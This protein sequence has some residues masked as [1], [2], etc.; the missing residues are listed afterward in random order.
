MA[1][2][3]VNPKPFLNDLTGKL[4]LVKLK[5]GMEYKGTLKSID[6]YMNLQVLNTEEWVEAA[7]GAILARS[8][9]VATMCSI[10]EECRRRSLTWTEFLVEVE[11]RCTL[12]QVKQ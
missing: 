3:P 4:I 2:V 12:R 6:P 10:S 9:S 5:W 1:T 8:S 7:S 11:A